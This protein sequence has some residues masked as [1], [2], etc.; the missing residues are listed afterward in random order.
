M[1]SRRSSSSSSSSNA[2][3][4]STT[5]I[6]NRVAG[7][8]GITLGSSSGNVV[9]VNE[10]S[11]EALANVTALAEDFSEDLQAGF[12]QIV[13]LGRD[14]SDGLK[15]TSE[16]TFDLANNVIERSRSDTEKIANKGLETAM[17]MVIAVMAL[18]AWQGRATA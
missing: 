4:V 8:A 18:F 10:M 13:G 7:G 1:S 9:T 3:S 6:D 14:L 11:V 12:A 5:A 15:V 16:S 2:T 17:V